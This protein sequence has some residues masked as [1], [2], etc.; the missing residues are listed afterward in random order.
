MHT[1]KICYS[2]LRFP[3]PFCKFS[4]KI[5]PLILI[6]TVLLGNI[7]LKGVVHAESEIR[8][9]GSANN[10]KPP[11]TAEQ[12]FSIMQQQLAAFLEKLKESERRLQDFQQKHGI[13][14]IETQIKLLLDQRK[15]LD[16]TM[17]DLR[18]GV[19]SLTRTI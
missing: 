13:I 9:E 3:F 6:G 14:S 17:Q 4:K 2:L 7:G 8:L 11:R 18:P 15:S 1:I 16:Y 5:F 10:E 19:S 12:A